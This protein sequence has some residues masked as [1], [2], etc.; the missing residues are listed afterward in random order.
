MNT[1]PQVADESA[2]EANRQAIAEIVA[3]AP[4]MTKEQITR[5]RRLFRYGRA[6]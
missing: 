6:T 5:I 3:R 4:R 2:E 1:K